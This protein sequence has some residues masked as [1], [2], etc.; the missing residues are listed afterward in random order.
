MTPEQT[1]AL[2]GVSPVLSVLLLFLI[3]RVWPDLMAARKEDREAERRERQELIQIVQSNT[4]S[5]VLLR[6]SIIAQ[7]QNI[8]RLNDVVLRLTVEMREV[9]QHLQLSD[10]E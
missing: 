1:A 4:E 3:Q 10:K 9:R 5:N 6:E 7:T 8:A 2:V